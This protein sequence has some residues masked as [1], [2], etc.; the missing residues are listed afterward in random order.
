MSAS[1]TATGGWKYADDPTRDWVAANNPA[2]RLALRALKQPPGDFPLPMFPRGARGD[3]NYFD[4]VNELAALLRDSARKL[5]SEGKLSDALDNYLA[6]ARLGDDLA[7]SNRLPS[8]YR[9]PN[10][11]ALAME[12]MDRWAI[13]PQQT[14][15]LIKRAISEFQQ[16][17][18]SAGFTSSRILA[19]WR[20]ERRIF[21]DYAWKGENPDRESRGAAETGFV[22][23]CLPWELLRLQRS[24]DA[25]YA[26]VLDD[27][28]L[29][30]REL[31]N[32]R[33][34][35][36]S[37]LTFDRSGT[38]W[39]WLDTTLWPPSAA[40]DGVAWK[41]NGIDIVNRA[42]RARLHFLAWALADYRREHHEFPERLAALVPTYFDWLPVDPWN[43][44]DFLYEP[45]GVPAEIDS[46]FG[47]KVK[48]LQPF[49]ASA[50]P[51]HARIEIQRTA[52]GQMDVCIL[53][54]GQLTPPPTALSV[55][56]Q[57]P[58]PALALPMPESAIK[59]KAAK[60]AAKKSA[61]EKRA[62]E[63]A[64][65]VQKPPAQSPPKEAQPGKA[66]PGKGSPRKEQPG[67]ESPFERA[68]HVLDQSVA[69]AKSAT[70]SKSAPPGK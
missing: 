4:R 47:E 15:D 53:E 10:T 5:E 50:G 39:T 19:D 52:G 25:V 30:E 67:K 37:L 28:Q 62:A 43:G 48:P 61:A 54:Q 27:T 18:Q 23:W 66:P 26:R 64:K 16:F 57:L 46:D 13:H 58:A 65:P 60:D 44:G 55:P 34:I 2:L 69:P 12:A 59:Q 42:A 33:F 40:V 11:S 17:E 6:M 7:R 24:Q 63:K 1:L 45:Q 21:E 20:T 3:G 68:D 8:Y 35:D 9:A 56:R 41:N 29:V 31:H 38:P 70:P 51:H 14:V 49:V 22:R 32:R 36:A